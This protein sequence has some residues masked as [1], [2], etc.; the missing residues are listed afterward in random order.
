MASVCLK[1]ACSRLAI[2][3]SAT[4]WRLWPPP[5]AQPLTAAMMTL[6]DVRMSRWTSRMWR[7]PPWRGRR[8]GVA[9]VEVAVPAPDA[10]VAARAERVH[11]VVGRAVAG[12]DDGGDVGGHAGVVEGPVELV[13]GL[14]PEGVAHLGPVEGDAHR[15]KVALAVAPCALNPPVVGDVTIREAV[16][17]APLRGIEGRRPGRERRSRPRA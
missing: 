8:G 2:E 15:G 17:G 7:R 16:D 14:G 10:L 3:R 11:A 6:G 4:T 5:A 1:R 12:E 9:L 13:D